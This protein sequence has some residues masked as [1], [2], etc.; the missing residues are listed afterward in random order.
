MWLPCRWGESVYAFVVS[1]A[2]HFED[3]KEPE[4]TR[5]D[6]PNPAYDPDYDVK[7]VYWVCAYANNQWKLGEELVSDL[8]Q[9]SFRKALD[10]AEGTVTVLDSGAVTFTRVWCCYEIFVSLKESADKLCARRAR[11]TSRPLS[12]RL[13]SLA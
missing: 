7:Q 1:L 8:K 5:W 6:E 11:S 10:R 3:H 9:T 2:R 13:A 12:S 4:E